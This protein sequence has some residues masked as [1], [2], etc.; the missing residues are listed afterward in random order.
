[1]ASH[2]LAGPGEFGYYPLLSRSGGGGDA[3]PKRPKCYF[4]L[5]LQEPGSLSGIPEYLRIAAKPVVDVILSG[6]NPNETP[7]QE[8][9]NQFG[10]LMYE[11]IDYI[12]SVLETC[13]CEKSGHLKRNE[14]YASLEA[15]LPPPPKPSRF[16]KTPSRRD[17][18][19][20]GTGL[21]LRD[22]VP[23]Q[24]KLGACECRGRRKTEE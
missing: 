9:L 10:G 6:G 8:L 5:A 14:P 1:M 13:T 20:A 18:L 2:I 4:N 24:A 23:I 11:D 17:R 7:R 21:L 22:M 12:G 19:Q 3:G 16:H 15:N